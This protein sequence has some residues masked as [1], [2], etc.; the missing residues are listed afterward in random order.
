MGKTAALLAVLG[1]L[2][3]NVQPSPTKIMVDNGHADPATTLQAA[4]NSAIAA[5]ANTFLV[6]YFFSGISAIERASCHLSN[7]TL[8][9]TIPIK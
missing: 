8:E 4:I 1:T 6:G 2:P 7:G 5:N 9:S 3:P